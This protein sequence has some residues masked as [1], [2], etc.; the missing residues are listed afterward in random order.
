[1][2]LSVDEINEIL[3]R[4]ANRGILQRVYDSEGSL[5]AD[6]L[7]EIK[8]VDDQHHDGQM[9]IMIVEIGGELYGQIYQ[10][11]SWGDTDVWDFLSPVEKVEV[12]RFE[13]KFK[14]DE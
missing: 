8:W 3:E 1:M 14:A 7:G 13:Y 5:E 11:S 6:G 4:P 12:T 10:Y 9:F 2:L